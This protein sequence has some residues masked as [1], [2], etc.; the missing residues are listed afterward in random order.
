MIALLQYF[1]TNPGLKVDIKL[2]IWQLYFPD[3]SAPLELR[4]ASQQVL[5]G[6]SEIK[7]TFSAPK[8]HDDRLCNR[9][10]ASKNR[11]D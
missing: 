10:T 6:V 7:D 4:H 11:G 9:C 3:I 5:S 8:A 1:V 2:K